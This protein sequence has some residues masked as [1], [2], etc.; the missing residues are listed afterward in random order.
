MLCDSERLSASTSIL[1]IWIIENKL[2]AVGG[3]NMSTLQG[4]LTKTKTSLPQ[5]IL[6]PIHLAANDGEQRFAVYEYP[7][8]VLF[9][10]FVKFP[11]LVDVF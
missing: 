4:A 7:H 3:R 11:G 10:D 2:G 6:L 9:N 5:R 1:D 8:T